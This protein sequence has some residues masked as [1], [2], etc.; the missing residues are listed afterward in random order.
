MKTNIQILQMRDGYELLYIN[1]MFIDSG[2]PLNRDSYRI[3]YFVNLGKKY[4]VPVK[5]MLFYD[6]LVKDEIFKDRFSEYNAKDL[7]RRG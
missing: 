6:S 5:D 4:N 2:K 1:D 7:V 3:M